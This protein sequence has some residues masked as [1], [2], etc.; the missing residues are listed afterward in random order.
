MGGITGIEA[1]CHC[2]DLHANAVAKRL[3]FMRGALQM[4]TRGLAINSHCALSPSS[5]DDNQSQL[6]SAG[7]SFHRSSTLSQSKEDFPNRSLTSL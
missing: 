1:S 6:P 4:H 2:T 7:P 5:G 3:I